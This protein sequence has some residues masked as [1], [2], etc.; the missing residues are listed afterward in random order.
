VT[1]LLILGRC[2][3]SVDL[4]HGLRGTVYVV[5]EA[6][7]RDCRE[8]IPLGRTKIP[9][10]GED[11]VCLP[12]VIAGLFEL[13]GGDDSIVITPPHSQDD[14]NPCQTDKSRVMPR[15]IVSDLPIRLTHRI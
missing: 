1:S 7:V 10:L 15:K 8:T 6:E 11:S 14:F 13:K 9:G 5:N 12:M 2:L 3:K 4:I